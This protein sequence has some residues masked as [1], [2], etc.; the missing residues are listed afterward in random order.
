MDCDVVIIGAGPAGT[1]AGAL[2]RQRGREVV[3]LEREQFPRFSIGESLLPQCMPVLEEAGLLD[4]VRAC[5]FQ[6]K[7]GAVFQRGGELFE[8][9]FRDGFTPGWSTAFQVQRARFD[10]ALADATAARGADVR[11]GVRVTEVD[12]GLDDCRVDYVDA[13]GHHGTV[14]ARFCL[15]ASGFGRVLA[16]TLDLDRPS[17]ATPRQAV[18]AHLK[19]PIGPEPFDAYKILINTYSAREDVWQ[20][21]I[22]FSDGTCSVG[23]VGSVSHFAAFPDR[24]DEAWR[25]FVLG[26][27][28][29]RGLLAEMQPVMP[30]RQIVGYARAIRSLHGDGY[31]ILGN[32]GE[33]LDPIFSSGVTIALKSAQLAVRALDK[34]FGG[35]VC[36]WETEFA[37]PL[38]R[39]VNTFRAFVDSWYDGRLLDIF[40]FPR[41]QEAI[42]R[43]LRSI[44]A[45]YA[46]DDANPFNRNPMRTLAALADLCR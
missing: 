29:L 46:W 36:D 3:I 24:P 13:D 4:A 11:Y 16:R 45:G 18:F 7:D 25:H 17:A 31:A 43:M 5:A 40:F 44:L 6:L 34:T 27:S 23:V 1:A 33:F 20:W 39:G 37:A 38:Q 19:G 2:L 9:G 14:R 41:K 8:L 32:A 28:Y 12:L 35:E 42:T 26:D 30:A 15:D 22:P 21:I 10:A